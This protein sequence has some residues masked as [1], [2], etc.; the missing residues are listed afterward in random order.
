[1]SN[2]SPIIPAQQPSHQWRVW[3]KILVIT[4]LLAGIA[5]VAALPI[6]RK[7]QEK[8]E[9]AAARAAKAAAMSTP[10]TD[11]QNAA[12]MLFGEGL[13]EMVTD[14]D[15][16]AVLQQLDTEAVADRVFSQMKSLSSNGEAR[17]GV[18]K[19][20]SKSHGGIFKTMMG[21][22]VRC[23]RIRERDGIPSL[24][25]RVSDLEG[26]LNFIEALVRSEGDSFR[27]VDL[28]TWLLGSYVSEEVRRALVL[29][30]K[31]PG[32]LATIFGVHRFDKEIGEAF[33]KLGVLHKNGELK[34]VIECLDELS[35]EYQ[36]NRTFFIFRIQT[37]MALQG[38]PE[39]EKPYYAALQKA[40][41][42]LGEGSATELLLIDLLMMDEDFLAADQAMERLS[43]RLG[44]DALLD[45]YRGL[46][47]FQQG[48]VDGAEVM[49]SQ[50][51]KVEPD[52]PDLVDLRL[53]I[54]A[55]RKNFAALVNELRAVQEL[56][57]QKLTDQ[58]LADPEFAEFLE[59]TEFQ[60][61]MKE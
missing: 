5:V 14:N 23:L 11:A 28:Y 2:S 40:P 6:V 8:N 55:R 37:L 52:L 35:P 30:M 53:P 31:D 7:L 25:M 10:L 1:M 39:Y 49:L 32:L 18:L 29:G 54:Y 20:L 50:A 36:D 12:L 51:E 60:D 46:L 21:Q 3:L 59:S 4:A 61:W 38:D 56:T 47:K 57:D 13:A 15:G 19:G 43:K 48:D 16:K 26:G 44:G 45:V 58:E 27:I 41:A 42:I 17:S 9:L 34:K 33:E 22:D 24:L